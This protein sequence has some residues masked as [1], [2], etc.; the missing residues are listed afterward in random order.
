MTKQSW[1][2]I[3]LVDKCDKAE[4]EETQTHHKPELLSHKCDKAQEQPSDLCMTGKWQETSED[5][6]CQAGAK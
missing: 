3:F 5:Q 2:V 4:H 6:E 1:S